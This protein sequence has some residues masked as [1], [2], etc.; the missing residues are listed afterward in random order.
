MR[1]L[2]RQDSLGG[3]SAHQRGVLFPLFHVLA[4]KT[5]E[6]AACLPVA[7]GEVCS[8]TRARAQRQEGRQGA[9]AYDYSLVPSL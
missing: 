4:Y 3:H 9:V 2:V 8:E 7:E 1:G 5:A 6:E